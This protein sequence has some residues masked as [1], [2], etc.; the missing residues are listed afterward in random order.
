M[1]KKIYSSGTYVSVSGW[2][3]SPA[4]GGIYINLTFSLFI[5]EIEKIISFAS[6]LPLQ[7]SLFSNKSI[8]WSDA[9]SQ[10]TIEMEQQVV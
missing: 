7:T 2:V 4:E 1:G 9:C 10:L 6:Q 5:Q 8:S 3:F